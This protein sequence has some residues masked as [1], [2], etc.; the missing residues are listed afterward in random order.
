MSGPL[1]GGFFLTHTVV[2]CVKQC[3]VVND[4]GGTGTC[5]HCVNG[6]STSEDWRLCDNDHS[7]LKVDDL[8][9]VA[10]HVK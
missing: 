1:R 2:C 4:H 6:H 5:I 9:T 3:H 10:L 7:R 8:F